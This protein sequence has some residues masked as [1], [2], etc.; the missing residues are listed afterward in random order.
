M[1]TALDT[2]V[3]LD[4]F[5][6]P[7]PHQDAALEAIAD[8]TTPGALIIS[9]LVY[10]ELAAGFEAQERLDAALEGLDI[11]VVP[12]GRAACYAAGRAFA[13][14]RRAGMPRRHILADFLIAAHACEHADRLL[15]RDRGF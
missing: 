6:L 8:A 10:A 2:N 13:A 15:T 4:L 14:Y 1:T 12:L 5:G 11:S 3:L 9:D 7:T